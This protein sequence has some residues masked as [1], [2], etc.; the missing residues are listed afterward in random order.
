[1][2]SPHLLDVYIGSAYSYSWPSYIKQTHQGMWRHFQEQYIH[3]YR[4]Y[5]YF[6]NADLK[7]LFMQSD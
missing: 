1:M 4:T 2:E 3:D 6:D 5:H 7:N